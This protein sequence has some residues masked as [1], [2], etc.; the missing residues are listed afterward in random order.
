MKRL[1]I[2]LVCAFGLFSMAHAQN[3][4]KNSESVASASVAQDQLTQ[5][6]IETSRC[7][8]EKAPEKWEMAFAALD[9]TDPAKP[10]LY[11]QA[12]V[13]GKSEPVSMIP[14]DVKKQAELVLS[15]TPLI[16]ADQQN[17]KKLFYR[18]TS[19]GEYIVFT[20]IEALKTQTKNDKS[21][22]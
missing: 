15:F 1:S 19:K 11:V 7:L 3:P 6:A 22:N 2:G 16:P 20:D 8:V 5:L 4:T 10:L 9:R 13:E 17:W 21:K 14:C 12:K 18:V